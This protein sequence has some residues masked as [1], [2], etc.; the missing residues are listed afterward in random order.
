MAFENEGELEQEQDEDF[1]EESTVQSTIPDKAAGVTQD[2]QSIRDSALEDAGNEASRSSAIDDLASKD[3]EIT[4]EDLKKLP[5]SEGMTDEQLKAEWDKA[6]SAE[7]GNADQQEDEKA[8]KL[9]FPIY[10][11]DGNK[12]EALEKISVRDL[13][14]G[15]LQLSYQAMGK[16][17]RK[18]LTEALRNASL[19]HWNEQKYNTTVEERNRVAQDLAKANTT[20]EKHSTERKVWDSALTALAMGNIEPMR[21]LAAAYQQKL[22]EVP[23]N[24][25]GMVS[26]SSV[27]A[28]RA[29]VAAGNQFIQDTIIPAGVDIATRYGAD[30]KEVLGAIEFFLKREPMQFLTREKIDSILKYDVPNVLEE[31]GYTPNGQRSSTGIKPAGQT[32]EI[33]E[34]KRT[35]AALQ[36]SMAE[37]KNQTVQNVRERTKKIPPSGGGAT[38]GA[39]DSMPSFKSRSQMKAWMQ[40][41]S[42]WAKA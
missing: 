38:P 16:E 36:S 1:T 13:L 11:K 25:P 12:V 39:G 10:D 32:N 41:D 7:K 20:L 40:G 3:G 35:V 42:E 30:P 14:E 2:R 31:N 6:V 4:I 8:F 15:K 23:Q 19:G 24:T 5:G 9:P 22:T 18:T 17:Q 37:K 33:D 21:Q 28:E 34:L 29:E 27:E 26:V